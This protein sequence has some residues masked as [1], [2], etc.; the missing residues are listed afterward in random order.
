M[1]SKKLITLLSLSNEAQ[2]WLKT[3]L[4]RQLQFRTYR[5]LQEITNL[6]LKQLRRIVNGETTIKIDALAKA[7]Q[8]LLDNSVKTKKQK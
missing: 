6:D 1:N 7:C 3:E 4:L 2:D 5:E 8:G